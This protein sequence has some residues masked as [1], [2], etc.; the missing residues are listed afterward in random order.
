MEINWKAR[1]V[2]PLCSLSSSMCA[3]RLQILALVWSVV[4]SAAGAAAQE[5][6][7][8]H[9]AEGFGTIN[10]PNTCAAAVQQDFSRAVAMLHSFGYGEARREFLAI[11]KKDPV[12]GM[13]QWA[14]APF[15]RIH[16]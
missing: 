3:Q 12:C 9:P 6:Q 14:P 15:P 13:A 2:E 10:F 4:T 8:Q 5:Q 7:H 11:A 1:I 16:S